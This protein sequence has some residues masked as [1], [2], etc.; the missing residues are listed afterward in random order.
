MRLTLVT[1]V[2][3]AALSGPAAAQTQDLMR[4]FQLRRMQSDIEAIRQELERRRQEEFWER[5]RSRS[6]AAPAPTKSRKAA[7]KKPLKAVSAGTQRNM[8]DSVTSDSPYGGR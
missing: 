6:N 7:P 8:W 3:L 4:D 5:Q 2:A 1:V